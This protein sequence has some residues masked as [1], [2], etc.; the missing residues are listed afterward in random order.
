MNDTFYSV[1]TDL[2]KTK[3]KSGND[4]ITKFTQI[5]GEVTDE[6]ENYLMQ[7]QLSTDIL[8][9]KLSKVDYIVS[10]KEFE[11]INT[12]IDLLDQTIENLYYLPTVTPY[13]RGIMERMVSPYFDSDH[14]REE[15]NTAESVQDSLLKEEFMQRL[16]VQTVGEVKNSL[17]QMQLSA[18]ILERRLSNLN[19]S[20]HK[21]DY[22]IKSIN[23]SINLVDKTMEGLLCYVG[24]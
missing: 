10:K 5:I 24:V 8:E 22:Y 19:S 23:T 7:I 3:I 2:R 13:D 14:G 9:R 4:K 1:P 20:V 12:G 21:K 17:M 11:Q 6:I 18:D 16:V 15:I